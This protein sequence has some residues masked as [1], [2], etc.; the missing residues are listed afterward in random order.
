M[1]LVKFRQKFE[2]KIIE[3]AFGEM[4]VA[5]AQHLGVPYFLVKGEVDETIEKGNLRSGCQM[6][7][8]QRP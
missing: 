8:L 4:C 5:L 2:M 1:K 3:S 7:S 6:R